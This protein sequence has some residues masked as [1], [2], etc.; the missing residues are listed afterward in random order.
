MLPCSARWSLS[1]QNRTL[2]LMNKGYLV[3]L[4][5]SDMSIVANKDIFRKQDHS[6]AEWSF[7]I[8]HMVNRGK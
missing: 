7:F 5:F 2:I 1:E 4:V 6:A 8:V 3:F